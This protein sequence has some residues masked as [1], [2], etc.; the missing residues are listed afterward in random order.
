MN[1][2]STDEEARK[3]LQLNG[4]VYQNH[5]LR[6]MM[7]GEKVKPDENKSIFIGNVSFSKL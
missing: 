6:V 4:Y 7:A 2:F 5:H 3:A 1:R